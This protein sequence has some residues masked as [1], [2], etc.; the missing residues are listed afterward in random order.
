MT[1]LDY[2]IELFLDLIAD[3]PDIEAVEE[4]DKRLQNIHDIRRGIAAGKEYD[5][6]REALNIDEDGLRVR[7]AKLVF[8]MEQ[9]KW[10]KAVRAVY[11]E[12]GF[13]RCMEWMRG[14]PEEEVQA[15]ARSRT[16]EKSNAARKGEA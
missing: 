11:G 9:R 14:T 1:M 10:S 7:R 5:G 15:I 3:M 2:P 13:L 6:D 12:E 16:K 8:R 4:I